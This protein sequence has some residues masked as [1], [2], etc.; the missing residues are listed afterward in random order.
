MVV[1]SRKRTVETPSKESLL[2]KIFMETPIPVAITRVK[3]GR[4]I[5]VNKASLKYMGL[6]RKDVIGRTSTELGFFTK[7][8]RQ[9]FVDDIKKQNFAVNVPIVAC[10]KNQYI[11]MLFSV[12]QFKMGKES[13]FFWLATDISNNNLDFKEFRDDKFIKI[14]RQNHK[15]IVDKIKHYPLT[16]RQKEIALLTLNGNSN[17]DIAKKLYI[18][19]YTVKDHM[20]EIFRVIGISN[21]SEFFSKLINY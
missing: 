2:R 7:D 18:S 8:K 21:R 20:K 1:K 4:Y 3:D 11:H 16:P 15:S 10:I 9:S 6:T 12:F 13:F 19:G 14:T 5:D 17:S